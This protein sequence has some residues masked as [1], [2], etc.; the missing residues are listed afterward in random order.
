[1]LRVG[2]TGGLGSGKSTAAQMFAAKGAY[3]LSADEIGREL[4]QPGQV[5]YVAIVERFGPGVVKAD[6]QLDRPALGRVAFGEGRIGELEA[7]V[8]PA[9]I[10]RQAE[11]IDGVA[12]R[13]ADAV[14]MV[15]S[16]LIFETKHGGE[17]GW[18]RRF[19]AVVFVTAPEELRI[20]RFVER[21]AGGK[22]LSGEGRVALEAEA[23]RRMANQVETERNA[24]QCEYVLRND[25]AL[26]E[27]RRQVD[28]VWPELR[29][30]AKG[31]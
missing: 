21:M 24:A 19:D 23:R 2:I 22:D 20:A 10:A 14:A 13:D 17:G 6:G 8:H 25:G 29:D 28:E 16:A 18:H 26:E 11:L 5:V 27:L 1:M 15:E 3:V 30:A 7:I 4:M 31:R 9:V 12:A